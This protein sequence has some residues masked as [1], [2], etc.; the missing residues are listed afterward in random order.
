[1]YVGG[2]VTVRAAVVS[3]I[4]SYAC[5]AKGELPINKKIGFCLVT[6]IALSSC[7]SIMS[8]ENPRT[9]T[10]GLNYYIPKK[11]VLVTVSVNNTSKISK[12][13]ISTTT[14]YPELSTRY[15][16]NHEGNAFG[17]NTLDVSVT[18][19][20]LLSATKSTTTNNVNQTFAN[21]ANSVGT[22][23]VLGLGVAA[24]P[25]ECAVTG[26]HTFV[27]KVDSGGGEVCGLQVTI[28]KLGVSSRNTAS[29][30]REGKAVSGIYYRQNEP[31][32]VSV[33]EL[34]IKS[35][36]IIFSPSQSDTYFLPVSKTFFADNEADFAFVDGVPTKYKQESDSELLSLFKLPADVIGE[37]F[38]AVGMVFDSFKSNDSKESAALTESIKLELE[39]VKFEACL[40]AIQAEEVDRI[41]ELGCGS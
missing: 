36:S 30:S 9:E 5:Q 18:T 22:I 4:S 11:D 16:L 34:G 28:R 20:G 23:G 29:G 39:R 21:L 12:V 37:Y 1:M 7:S 31:Y 26:D 38:S 10:D 25:Q 14:A 41:K 24:T 2:T 15:V 35:S 19:N 40:S 6:C 13:A 27:L 8:I 33:S 17:S 32:E 3:R